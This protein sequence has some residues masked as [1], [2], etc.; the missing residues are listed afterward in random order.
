[1]SY[2]DRAFELGDPDFVETPWKKLTSP[3]YAESQAARV[4]ATASLPLTGDSAG[5]QGKH[6][7]HHSVVDPAGNAVAMTLSINLPFGSGKVAP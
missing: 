4:D 5:E 6:T 1:M 7:T 3:E 2:F